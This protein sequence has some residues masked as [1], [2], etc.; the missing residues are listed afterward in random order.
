ME[1]E[2]ILSTHLHCVIKNKIKKKHLQCG[3]ALGGKKE[4]FLSFFD[5]VMLFFKTLFAKPS[6]LSFNIMPI[7][8]S[9][10][11]HFTWLIYYCIFIALV[12]HVLILLYMMGFVDDCVPLSSHSAVLSIFLTVN[13][14]NVN[15][16]S[17][18]KHIYRTDL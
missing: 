4:N 12:V 14:I 3:A 11:V 18:E 15:F 5:C 9:H 13:Q 10:T 7:C 1:E 2:K 17:K 8:Y 6:C 16:C